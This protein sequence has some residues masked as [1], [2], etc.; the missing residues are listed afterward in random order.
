MIEEKGLMAR[1]P[2][3]SDQSVTSVRVVYSDLHGVTRGKD[4]PIG[5]FDRAADHGL[6]FCSAIM[7]TDLRHTPVVGSEAG[8]PDLIAKP[9]LTTLTLLPW[10]PGVA[11][12][13]ADLEA[14]SGTSAT[15]ADPR[16]AVRKAVAGFEELGYAPIVGPELEFFLCVPDPSAP[17][18]HGWFYGCDFGK[19]A[20][21]SGTKPLK[22][23]SL[24]GTH[25]R[26]SM[27]LPF[28]PSWRSA[29]VQL[30]FFA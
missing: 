14:V 13:I 8:Y 18:I 28:W 26:N 9:D 3:L 2:E 1:P 15:P 6:A 30:C 10:E 22:C 11:C 24:S 21:H 29:R 20:S 4:V 5:E 17:D 16:G 19:T 12:C 25:A 7:G 27:P 23:V